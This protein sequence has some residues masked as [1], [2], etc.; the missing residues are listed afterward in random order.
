[1]FI[2]G[3]SE[4]QQRMITCNHIFNSL[5]TAADRMKSQS[6]HH[7]QNNNLQGSRT[8]HSRFSLMPNSRFVEHSKYLEHSEHLKYLEYALLQGVRSGS[9]IVV[10]TILGYDKILSP[11][12]FCASPLAFSSMAVDDRRTEAAAARTEGER[13]GRENGKGSVRGSAGITNSSAIAFQSDHLLSSIT[14]AAAMGSL[15][16]IRVLIEHLKAN[17]ILSEVEASAKISFKNNSTDKFSGRTHR[18]SVRVDRTASQTLGSSFS[19]SFSSSSS[20]VSSSRNPKKLGWSVIH[21]VLTGCE[22]EQEARKYEILRSAAYDIETIHN[23]NVED[24]DIDSAV[25]E[26]NK[27]TGRNIVENEIKDVESFPIPESSREGARRSRLSHPASV[28]CV[29]DLW[30]FNS[31]PRGGNRVG[32]SRE[33]GKILDM[34][35]EL[36][37]SLRN[38][39]SDVVLFHAE[40]LGRETRPRETLSSSSSIP[41][42]VSIPSCLDLAAS[43]GY[44][45]AVGLMLKLGA[46]TGMQSDAKTNQ[47]SSIQTDGQ[48]SGGFRF[49]YLLHCAAL[50]RRGEIFGNKDTEIE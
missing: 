18:S 46:L 30:T 39:G 16:I 50:D 5:E 13:K 43:S 42:S 27:R 28:Y 14:A 34:L 21:A 20:S 15:P 8:F 45:P 32:G 11:I 36:F 25:K 19:S 4:W 2:T 44:W 35:L 47:Q 3:L 38:R 26:G 17:I 12:P 23:N 24:G 40:D 7:L 1:M 10:R 37:L 49:Y 33:R 9:A 31:I 22:N 48:L 6:A 41:L 29:G